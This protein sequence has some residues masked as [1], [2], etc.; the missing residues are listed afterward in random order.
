MSL[1]TFLMQTLHL[2]T[3]ISQTNFCFYKQFYWCTATPSI[4]FLGP[5]CVMWQGWVVA[6]ETICPTEPE[7]FTICPFSEK[8]RRPVLNG[9]FRNVNKIQRVKLQLWKAKNRKKHIRLTWP[10]TLNLSCKLTPMQLLWVY[11]CVQSSCTKHR[12]VHWPTRSRGRSQA[13]RGGK[14][15]AYVLTGMFTWVKQLPGL[16]VRFVFF[17]C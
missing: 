7:I 5:L 2:K 11:S 15:E 14:K 10:R 16:H 4:Y 17:S 9:R 13:W 8:A 12:E 6:T 1:L 3:S